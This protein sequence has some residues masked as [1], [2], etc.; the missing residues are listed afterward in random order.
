MSCFAL[1]GHIRSAGLTTL[2]NINA[3]TVTPRYTF[4][5]IPTD[6]NTE[7][8][9]QGPYA[10]STQFG[11]YWNEAYDQLYGNKINFRVRNE[12][13]ITSPL[14]VGMSNFE[15]TTANNNY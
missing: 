5:A 9:S 11:Y 13:P 12:N 6:P 4:P 7:L 3:I 14:G 15:T 2:Y 10:F 8:K 1:S